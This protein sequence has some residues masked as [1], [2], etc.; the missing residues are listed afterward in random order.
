MDMLAEFL[1]RMTINVTEFYRNPNRW[2]VL[3]NKI[4]P[5]LM[6]ESPRLK[7]WSAA[8][9]TGEE[10]YTLSML[11]SKYYPLREIKVNATDIDEFVM[12]RAKRGVYMEK[13]LAE[14]P[15]ELLHKFFTKHED[16][17]H[18]SQEVKNCV[19]FKKQNLLSDTF[20]TGFDLIICR[21]VMIYFT[22]DAKDEIYHKFSA[23]LRRG[24]VLFVGSTE[25]IFQPQIFNFK[26]IDTFFYQKQ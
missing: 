22:E 26:S 10:P 18:I 1:D 23:S 25:Q 3:Q 17:Y 21:N 2:D 20:E 12:A 4:I 13:A 15:K 14:L 11:L 6:K 8:C 19:T 7:C 5:L 24:G 9:S 16:E